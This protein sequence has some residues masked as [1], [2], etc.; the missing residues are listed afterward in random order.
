[1]G[2]KNTP[3]ACEDPT[4]EFTIQIPCVLADRIAAY[5]QENETTA[6]NV[7]VEA[8]DNFLRWRSKGR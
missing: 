7:V 5:A 4:Q 3:T 8:V 2:K 1:M 6:S